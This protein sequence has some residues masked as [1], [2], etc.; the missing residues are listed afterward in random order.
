MD[1]QSE[2]TYL[3]LKLET[4]ENQVVPYA[5]LRESNKLTQGIRRWKLDWADIENRFR[6]RRR[7]RQPEKDRANRA[8]STLAVSTNKR[9]DVSRDQQ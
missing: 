5:P 8:D 9:A 6:L 2:L 7:K 4:L 1:D 3:K